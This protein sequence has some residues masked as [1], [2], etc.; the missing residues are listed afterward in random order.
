M[1]KFFWYSL[2]LTSAICIS[3]TSCSVFNK[4]EVASEIDSNLSQIFTEIK[5]AN[6]FVDTNT[7]K[8]Y[9]SYDSLFQKLFNI[10]GN[11]TYYESNELKWVIVNGAEVLLDIDDY[12]YLTLLNLIA[13][14]SSA[15]LVNIILF[16]FNW[17]I[18]F[19][20]YLF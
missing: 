6:A 1:Q 9:K 18:I 16:L 10:T 12:T 20:L 19:I 3:T 8:C 2:L 15:Y 13:K 14:I 5:S 4:R 17:L 11:S 7:I